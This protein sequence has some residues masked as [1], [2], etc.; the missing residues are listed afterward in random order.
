MTTPIIC[1][2]TDY[3]DDMYP[4]FAPEPIIE[5]CTNIALCLVEEED[6][7]MHAGGLLVCGAHALQMVTEI[8]EETGP[9]TART[10]TDHDMAMYRAGVSFARH[11]PITSRQ[12]LIASHEDWAAAGIYPP[13]HSG[14]L[15]TIGWERTLIG[16]LQDEFGED[17][18]DER[19]TCPSCNG[20]GE[21]RFEEICAFCNGRGVQ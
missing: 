6:N 18:D 13:E 1:H 19:P 3:H 21:T 17:P 12:A 10:L 15:F 9:F 14:Q 7:E 4:E 11:Q 2:F 8:I 20:A 5:S 16:R